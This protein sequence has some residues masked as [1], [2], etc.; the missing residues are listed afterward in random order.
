MKNKTIALFPALCLFGLWL[1]FTGCASNY[2]FIEP[3][4][5]DFQQPTDTLTGGLVQITWRYNVLKDAGNRRYARKEKRNRVSLLALRIDNRSADTL[6]FPEDFLVSTDSVLLEPLLLEE[7]GEALSQT[8]V[9]D[10]PAADVDAG[11]TLDFITGL[12]N[13]GI[14]LKANLRFAKEMMEYYLVYSDIMPGSVVVG[15][16]ALP[17][18]SGAPLKFSDGRR[19]GSGVQEK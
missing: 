15:L 7:A 5:L 10:N 2:H 14:Q 13:T 12:F 4:K 16:V 17:V 19:E 9:E 8:F 6:R 11:T 18:K 3:L 1:F